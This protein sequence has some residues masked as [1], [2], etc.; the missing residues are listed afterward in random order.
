MKP[1]VTKH[2]MSRLPTM[3][4][5]RMCEC[6]P[7]CKHFVMISDL[8][9]EPLTMCGRDAREYVQELIDLLGMRGDENVPRTQ[10]GWTSRQEQLLREY[11]LNEG[12]EKDGSIKYGVYSILAEKVGKTR[13]QV[14]GK[15]QRMRQ[16]GKLPATKGAS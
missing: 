10:N 7:M 5:L 1:V 4:Q 3:M 6:K 11:L 16:E 9:A 14:K 2:D 15:I 13:K 12:M 8:R